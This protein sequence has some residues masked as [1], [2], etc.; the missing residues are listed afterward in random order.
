MSEEGYWYAHINSMDC[1]CGPERVRKI[2]RKGDNEMRKIVYVQHKSPRLI[3]EDRPLSER[4]FVEEMQ[5][6]GQYLMRDGSYTTDE[7]RARE[8][9]RLV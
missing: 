1:P 3:E 9:W 8:S 6:Q 4:E 7:Y 2:T 5:A